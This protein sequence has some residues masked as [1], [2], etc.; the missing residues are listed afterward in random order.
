MSWG[1]EHI[2]SMKHIALPWEFLEVT[3]DNFLVD[4]YE[5]QDSG[6]SIFFDGK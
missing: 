4:E 1:S 6:P 3:I 5:A 2:Y